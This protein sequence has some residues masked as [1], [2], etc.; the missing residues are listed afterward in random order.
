MRAARHIKNAAVIRKVKTSLATP[1]AKGF[2]AYGGH[3][4]QLLFIYLFIYN[5]LTLGY[6]VLS[7][8]LV[9]MACVLSR[10]PS[11]DGTPIFTQSSLLASIVEVV[12]FLVAG[13]R[14]FAVSGLW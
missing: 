4:A 10:A 7:K 3:Y 11:T 2:Y 12:D 8:C 13:C 5:L 9:R 1:F 14:G 6:R